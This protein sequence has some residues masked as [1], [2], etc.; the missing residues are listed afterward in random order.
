MVIPVAEPG[1]GWQEAWHGQDG[2]WRVNMAGCA[3]RAGSYEIEFDENEFK[4]CT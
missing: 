1:E 3:F 2:E 4:G